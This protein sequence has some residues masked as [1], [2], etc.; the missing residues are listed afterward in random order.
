[1]SKINAPKILKWIP[2]AI[3]GIVAVVQTLGEQK[4]Q[5]RIDDMDER[6]KS[7]EKDESQ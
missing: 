6:I 5:E 1:M 7:L 3:A 2:V 4:Q